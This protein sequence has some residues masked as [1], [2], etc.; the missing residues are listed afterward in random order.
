MV[1]LGGLPRN[2]AVYSIEKCFTDAPEQ[3]RYSM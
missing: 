3:A 2:M 1:I